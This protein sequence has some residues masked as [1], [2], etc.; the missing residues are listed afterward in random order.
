M[1]CRNYGIKF[2]IWCPDFLAEKT[3]RNSCLPFYLYFF[4]I[5]FFFFFLTKDSSPCSQ[6]IGMRVCVLFSRGGAEV[7]LKLMIQRA[8]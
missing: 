5:F 1:G 6:P 7:A 3:F 4:F 8:P 2:P